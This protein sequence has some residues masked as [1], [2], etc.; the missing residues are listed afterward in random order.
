MP[1]RMKL[2]QAGIDAAGLAA[3]AFED[4]F[5]WLVPTCRI[6]SL[7][8]HAADFTLPKPRVSNRAPVS[9]PVVTLLLLAAMV[10]LAGRKRRS[11]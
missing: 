1:P 11:G 7:V 5:L 3:E 10:N 9:G 2:V 8:G 6:C 4:Q